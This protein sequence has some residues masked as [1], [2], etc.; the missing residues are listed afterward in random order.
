MVSEL[1]S[2]LVYPHHLMH[3]CIVNKIVYYVFKIST[4][5]STFHDFSR[6]CMFK[7]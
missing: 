6:E 1:V 7:E 4:V 5:Q 3:A 2:L